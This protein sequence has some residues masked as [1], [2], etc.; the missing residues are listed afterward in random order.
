M[1]FGSLWIVVVRNLVGLLL[2]Y[3]FMVFVFLLFWL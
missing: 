2:A 1:W 3:G